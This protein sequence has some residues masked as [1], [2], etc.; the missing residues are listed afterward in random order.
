MPQFL[1]TITTAAVAVPVLLVAGTA[2]ASQG[3][4]V[5]PG[6]AGPTLQLAMAVV[7]YGGSALLVVMGLIGAIRHR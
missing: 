1:R 3:P 5:M 2:F 4:G 6:T 7:V